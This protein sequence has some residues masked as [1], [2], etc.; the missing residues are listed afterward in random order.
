MTISIT[1]DGTYV[2]DPAQNL[3]YTGSAADGPSNHELYVLGPNGDVTIQGQVLVQ[4]STDNVTLYGAYTNAMTGMP[5]FDIAYGGSFTVTESSAVS[6]AEGVWSNNEPASFINDGTFSVSS[7]AGSGVDL[8]DGGSFSNTGSMTVT[9][10]P[11]YSADGVFI[12]NPGTASNTG[13]IAVSGGTVG[14]VVLTIYDGGTFTNSGTI[15]ATSTGPFISYEFPHPEAWGIRVSGSNGG[16]ETIVN[17]GTINATTTYGR[18]IA[19]GA[20]TFSGAVLNLDLTNGPTGVL[21]GDIVLNDGSGSHIV[22]EGTI[23]GAVT[24]GVTGN[25]VYDGRGG[26]LAD[27]LTLGGGADT[28]YLGNDGETV[29]AGT[30][31]A[32]IYGGTGND[33]ITGGPGA[34]FITGGG[35]ADTL[36]GGA[37]ADTFAF[38]VPSGSVTI[39][40]FSHAQG[41]KIDLSALGYSWAD[42]QAH[43]VTSGSNTVISLPDGLTITLVGVT[44]IQSSDFLSGTIQVLPTDVV[45]VGASVTLNLT[46]GSLAEFMGAGGALDNKG[47]MTLTSTAMLPGIVA[48]PALDSTAIFT[49]DGSFTVT[50]PNV[51]GVGN[52]STGQNAV[53]LHNNGTFAVNGT[54]GAYQTTGAMGDVVNAGSMTI[55][56]VGTTFGVLD[57]NVGGSFVNLAGGTFSVVSTTALAIGVELQAGGT[58]ENAGQLT[59]SGVPGPYG[60]E[61]EGV[62]YEA[63]SGANPIINSGTITV[64]AS[65]LTAGIGVDTQNH[66]S[67]VT[68]INSGTITAQ[69]AIGYT[70]A[71]AANIINTGTVNGTVI[72]GYAGG[73]ID[74]HAG[75]INGR[76]GLNGGSSTVT[77]A[78]EDNTVAISAGVNTADGGGGT[79]TVSYT[80]APSG[81]HVSLAL[82]GQA[83]STGVSTDTL[84][85]FQA[86]IGSAHNDTLEGGGSAASTLTGGAGA[87]TFVYQPG[88]GAVTVTDFSDAQGDK[89]DIDG[90]PFFTPND[91]LAAS[92]QVGSDTV[93]AIGA[94]SL[95]LQNVSLTSLT[96]SDFIV[97]GPT[98]GNG[99]LNGTSGND[100]LQGGSGAD[101][102]HGGVGSDDLDGGGGLNTALYDGVYQQYSVGAGGA[103]VCGGPETGTDTLTNIQRIQFVDGYVA[104][105][106]TD[107]AGEVYRLYEATLNRGPDPEGLAGW[108][109]QLNVGTSLQTVADGFVGSVEFQQVYGNL[110]NTDFVTLLY[111]NV[112]HRGPDPT[113]LSG[114]VGLLNSGQDT[115]SQVVLGF[116]QSPEDITNST[117]AVDQGLWVG[118]V[119]AARVARL[120]DTVLGRLPD[121]PGLA[122]WTQALE[123][124]TLTLLQEVNDFMTSA[125][126]QAVYGN[127][128]NTDFVTLLYTNALHRAPD[129]G[130][131]AWVSLLNSGQY[132]RAQV[133]QGFSESP[134]QV[135]DTAPHIDG[136]IW[137]A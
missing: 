43:A 128:S 48:V 11:A 92:S 47:S 116:S 20:G 32:V 63:S 37:G 60:T 78:A 122:G 18:G 99:T 14:G 134:E 71:V 112:L 91:V 126:F 34:D 22:N 17:T 15:S 82:E 1:V 137:L 81:V 104:T 113:G 125:E 127:L 30:G 66:V 49:N 9:A 123:N 3:T 61:V 25:D 117:P 93:V 100:W 120:Y 105:S 42:V 8:T 33:T 130:L 77:L 121:L 73:V 79:N 108:V 118:D 97:T 106:P 90:G 101:T 64:S 69:S 70:S 27:G 111:N 136:G 96:A 54:S 135:A 129:A 56:G 31:T 83:Q 67:S 26:T 75:T 72:L 102:L 131:T 119:D 35:G 94:G 21:N 107:F 114:W 65:S 57:N 85:H 6:F 12:Q 4:D 19:I 109:N 87:D 89:I 55:R 5:T 2:V 133:V 58:F 23:H 86:L 132:T 10:D 41:D 16:V 39:T 52:V 76:V 53:T 59:V 110:S 103:T 51:T 13:S 44:S 84:T 36:T 28:V 45:V 40:D 80:Y 62:L 124:G 88:D 29:N 24:L 7:A 46:T 38:R 115:R 95:R 50:T 74:S 98:T 68:L